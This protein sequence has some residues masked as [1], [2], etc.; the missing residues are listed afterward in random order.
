MPRKK[1]I[2]RPSEG[3]F[4]RFT[5]RIYEKKYPGLKDF[6]D[7]Q[8]QSSNETQ[9]EY[10]SRILDKYKDSIEFSGE[11]QKLAD[12]FTLFDKNIPKRI[13]YYEGVLIKENYLE[14]SSL[15]DL[16]YNIYPNMIERD[17]F[18]LKLI[19]NQFK[20]EFTLLDWLIS[21]V[22]NHFSQ[23]LY[24]IE[25]LPLNE[26]DNQKIYDNLFFNF[27]LNWFN[28]LKF[29]RV[30]STREDLENINFNFDMLEKVL[31]KMYNGYQKQLSDKEIHEKTL[32]NRQKKKRTMNEGLRFHFNVL[33]EEIVKRF[34]GVS[35]ED[36]NL[37]R[38]ELILFHKIGYRPSESFFKLIKI[39]EYADFIEK[40][41][42]SKSLIGSIYKETVIY[43]QINSIPTMPLL[44][45]VIDMK[46]SFRSRV[47]FE[48]F[49]KDLPDMIKNKRYN[50]IQNKVIAMKLKLLLE[51]YQ[52]YASFIEEGIEIIPFEKTS[53]FTELPENL[54]EAYNFI[55]VYLKRKGFDVES[56]FDK[57]KSKVEQR[58]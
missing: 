1:Q 33:F 2:G 41:N 6:I 3:D 25:N 22:S 8:S 24:E 54:L 9:N 57:I 4:T 17:Q 26:S 44:D 34:N 23:F 52:D 21:D 7:K 55:R 31:F 48:A 11:P 45:L 56:D 32:L 29:N 50:F 18:Y 19:H 36:F 35:D 53:V 49:L 20:S 47:N 16:I 40:H 28:E 15:K 58:F 42:L 30:I 27:Q 10:I 38:N 39:D 37:N 46:I 43:D 5:F 12:C 14:K 13:G 51:N